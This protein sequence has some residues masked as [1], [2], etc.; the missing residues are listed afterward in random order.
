MTNRP[1]VAG[2]AQLKEARLTPDDGVFELAG[3]APT[4]IWVHT[5]PTPKCSCRSALVLATDAGRETLLGRGTVVREAWNA[6]D[7]Y[8]EVAAKLDELVVF[9]VDIDT[10]EAY[11]PSGPDPLD[12]AKHPR[13]SRSRGADRRRSPR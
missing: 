9:H 4:W 3:P 6:G 1:L 8:A 2:D 7:G 5:C 11:P 10:V 12:L 13:I